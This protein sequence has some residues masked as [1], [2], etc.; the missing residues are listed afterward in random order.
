[1]NSRIRVNVGLTYKIPM[2]ATGAMQTNHI[3]RVR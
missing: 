3:I 2:G 1:M